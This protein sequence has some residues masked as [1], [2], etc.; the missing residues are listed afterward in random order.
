MSRGET[1]EASEP[2]L[3]VELL[4]LTRQCRSIDK[5]VAS[6]ARL[7]IDEMH[8]LSVLF[9]E[10]PASIRRLYELINVTPSRASK[11]LKHLELRG[12]VSRSIDSTDH[13]RGQ[14]VLTEAGIDAVGTILT[15]FSELGTE[16]LGAWRKELGADFP[17]LLKTAT[18]SD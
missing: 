5:Y 1:V 13:R 8:C 9:C 11:I 6:S 7:T 14:V 18:H 2:R 3:G 17:W 4:R 15:H 16:F 12:L 10:R